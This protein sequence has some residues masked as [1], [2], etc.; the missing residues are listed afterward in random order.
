MALINI[1]SGP[2]PVKV[3]HDFGKVYSFVV[4]VVLKEI[5]Q[6]SKPE[7]SLIC[8]LCVSYTAYCLGRIVFDFAPSTLNFQ[9]ELA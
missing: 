7:L 9:K 5:G 4:V 2:H 3:G 1:I 8:V 6:W